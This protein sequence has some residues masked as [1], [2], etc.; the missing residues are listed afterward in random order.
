MCD[1]RDHAAKPAMAQALLE[2]GE[3]Q[4]FL[5]AGLKTKNDAVRGEARL[6]QSRREEVLPG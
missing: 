5:V 3:A 6:R 2:Q 1:L 4:Y